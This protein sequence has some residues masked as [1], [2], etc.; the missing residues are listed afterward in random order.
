MTP[1]LVSCICPTYNRFPLYSKLLEECTY[2]F[3]KQDYPNKELIIL[4]DCKEQ[5]LLCNHKEIKI[6]NVEEKFKTLGDKYNAL[7]NL[8]GGEIILPWEDDDISLPR[9]ISQSVN[10]LLLSSDPKYPPVTFAPWYPSGFR[11]EIKWDYFNPQHSWF[12]NGG[13]LH[14]TH[15]HGVCQ[16]ASAFRKDLFRF[17]SVNGNQDALF[18]QDAKRQGRVAP[19]LSNNPNDWTYVYR[20]G[21]SNYHLSGFDDM[22]KAYTNKQDVCPGTF[23]IVPKMYK[24][25]DELCKVQPI[26]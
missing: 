12:E 10:T 17:Q 22:N 24:P 25:Y 26:S 8:C 1:P 18:D 13:T 23:E 5:K 14:F 2:W 19:A 21:V 11:T 20:W 6:F 16:N 15:S 4:N 9:R 7:L 3:L